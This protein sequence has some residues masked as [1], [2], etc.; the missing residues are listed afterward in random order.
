MESVY[1]AIYGLKRA[2]GIEPPS[3]V[4]KTVVL[5]LNYARTNT[6]VYAI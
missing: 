4:W 6:L 1:S 5:P 3:T 2:G